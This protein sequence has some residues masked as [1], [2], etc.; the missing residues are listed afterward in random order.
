[1]L[2]EINPGMI[3]DMKSIL[4]QIHLK[5]DI[6]NFDEFIRQFM[7]VYNC[8]KQMVINHVLALEKKNVLIWDRTLKW[9]WM[10]E[11]CVKQ[12]DFYGNHEFGGTAYY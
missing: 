5:D 12:M 1:M 11:Y 10:D 8:S 4:F 9:V 3:N 7:N 6:A 2:K